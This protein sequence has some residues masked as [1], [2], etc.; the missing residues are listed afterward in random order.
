VTATALPGDWDALGASVVG[1]GTNVAVWAP[2]ATRVQVCLLDD[3][4]GEQ[5]V[6]LVDQRHHVWHGRLPGIGAGTRYGFRVHGPW[7]PERG[8]RFN[9]GKLLLDPYARAVTGEL[10]YDPAVYG[11]VRSSFENTGDDRVRSDA[12][13]APFVPTGVVV[14]DAFDWAG[15]ASPRIRWSDTVLYEL[16]VRGYTMGHPD[17]PPAMRGTYAGLAHPAVL[18]HLTSLGVTSVE[19]LP[20]HH[21]VREPHLAASGMTNYWGYNSLAFFAPHAAYSAS[22]TRGQQVSEFKAMVKAMHAAGLEVVLDVVYNHT[23]EQGRDGPTLSLRGLANR[24]YYRLGRSG[25]DYVDYTGCGNTLDVRNPHTL[26]L[27]TDS[28]RYWV[29]EMHVDGFRFDLAAALARSMHDVDMLGAFFAVIQQDPVLRQVKLIAEPWDVG[30]GGYQVGEFPSLWTEWNDRYRDTLRDYWRGASDGVR[31]LAMRVSGSSDLYDNTSRRP[32]ASINYVT[33][34]DGFTLRDLVSYNE[35]HNHSNHQYN[36]DGHGDNRSSNYGVEGP[37]DDPGVNAVRRRQVANMLTT[38]LLSTGVPMLTAGDEMGRTQQ[39]NNN[40]YCQ[41][42]EISWVDWGE[43]HKWADL[44]AL[45]R[46]VLTIRA[47]NPVFRQRHFFEGRPAVEGG[48]KDVAWFGTHGSELDEQEWWQ[49]DRRVLGMF[50]AGDAIRSRNRDGSRVTGDSFL[51]WLNAAD[52]DVEVTLPNH[53]HW[54][55]AYE[56][57]LDTANEQRVG[58][59]EAG[60]TLVLAARSTVLLR[61]LDEPIEA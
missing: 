20:V 56:P 51:L 11:H 32:F 6:D 52:H 54:A 12:D 9:P 55:Q 27:V 43:A 25:R 47:A 30:P 41:D 33:A 36:T 8:L 18:E 21:F 14:D 23:A 48:R 45:V 46:S 38:L 17:V 59:L 34:H 15:D 26:Q 4:G 42:N 37:T 31:D 1:D 49:P 2:E 53:D 13:S 39:G 7:D 50:L 19:L 16:N 57:M 58:L 60:H 44:T 29:T 35:R 3:D 40:A 28:L 61:A 10:T 24:H 5:R 22:G